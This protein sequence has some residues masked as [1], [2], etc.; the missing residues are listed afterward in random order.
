VTTFMPPR[1][2]GATLPDTA[3]TWREDG[4]PLDPSGYTWQVEARNYTGTS[5]L[6]TKTT[7]FTN[8]STAGPTVTVAWTA[9]D[10]GSLPAGGYVLELTG[11]VGSKSRKEQIRLAVTAEVA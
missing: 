3:I 7:G 4:T 11:T 1:I 10:L 5:I 9:L 8:G 2:V 6:F